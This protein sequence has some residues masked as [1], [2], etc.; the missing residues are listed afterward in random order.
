MARMPHGG[1]ESAAARR[2]RLGHTAV[3]TRVRP[4]R[5]VRWRRQRRIRTWRATAPHRT[6]EETR[7][8]VPYVPIDAATDAEEARVA[9]PRGTGVF[10]SVFGR[11]TSG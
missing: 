7:L 2:R 3:V 6:G 4:T 10:D 5:N 1:S 9:A 8:L 11:S